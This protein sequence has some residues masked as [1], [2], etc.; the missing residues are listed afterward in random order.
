MKQLAWVLAIFLFP[1]PSYACLDG[2][3]PEI[4]L[5]HFN[6]FSIP[7]SPRISGGSLTLYGNSGAVVS[8]NSGNGPNGYCILANTGD[9]YSVWE[10]EGIT[11]DI[12]FVQGNDGTNKRFEVVAFRF[13][14]REFGNTDDVEIPRNLTIAG[15]N[16]S[17]D[18]IIGGERATGL[19]DFSGVYA[20]FVSIGGNLAI[21]T[22]NFDDSILLGG[23]DIQGSVTIRTLG[24]DDLIQSDFYYYPGWGSRTL[25]DTGRGN[26]TFDLGLENDFN[27]ATINMGADDDILGGVLF[28]NDG[29]VE[30]NTAYMF[31]DGSRI[32]INMGSGNDASNYV[33]DDY[34][35][36]SMVRHIDG[37][38]ND[39]SEIIADIINYN[40]GPGDDNLTV[41]K[42]SPSSIFNGSTGDDILDTST[43]TQGAIRNFENVFVNG[44]APVTIA[45][46]N[47]FGDVLID[48][49]E[50]FAELEFAP[51]ITSGPYELTLSPS[52]GGALQVATSECVVFESG[53]DLCYT[54]EQ[55][56]PAGSFTRDIVIKTNSTDVVVK[57]LT[58]PR[59]FVLKSAQP[60]TGQNAVAFLHGISLEME[61][62]DVGRNMTVRGQRYDDVVDIKGSTI[63][64]IAKIDTLQGDDD[65][66][67]VS[68]TFNKQFIANTSSGDDT[69]C[70]QG[71]SF[72]NTVSM[73]FSSGDDDL[74]ITDSTKDTSVGGI[75]LVG[76]TGIDVYYRHNAFRVNDKQPNGRQFMVV[77]VPDDEIVDCRGR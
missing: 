62:V 73:N 21:S 53:I 30:L 6:D 70:V 19:D 10:V 41:S 4:N 68:S 22:K 27:I 47:R 46:T 50:Q 43:D 64:G 52:A 29:V 54:D 57:D 40:G 38:G 42:T 25:I 76:G 23:T 48:V 77:R 75:R 45:K 34:N 32:S 72:S 33:I 31:T 11:R 7:G 14:G 2:T 74:T 60:L 49:F 61:N 20:G 16:S 66:S 13:P 12:R 1:F 37:T 15:G 59:D 51:S 36:E 9:D 67:V 58:V 18:V 17:L 44:E 24:G 55:E 3:E 71:S 5:L 8:V 39:T 56:L 28:N 35:T 65:L 63:A 26:D 69:T